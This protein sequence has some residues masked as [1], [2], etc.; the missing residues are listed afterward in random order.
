MQYFIIETT[1]FPVSHSCPLPLYQPLTYYIPP[2]SEVHDKKQKT[3]SLEDDKK[4]DLGS[5]ARGFLSG[6]KSTMS[7]IQHNN[8]SPPHAQST[9]AATHSTLP[10]VPM[11]GVDTPGDSMPLDSSVSSSPMAQ[12]AGRL[13]PTQPE[14]EGE[15]TTKTDEVMAG[16][17]HFIHEGGEDVLQ[18]KQTLAL[19]TKTARHVNAKYRELQRHKRSGDALAL[20]STA[21]EECLAEITAFFAKLPTIRFKKDPTATEEGVP[22]ASEINLELFPHTTCLQLTGLHVIHVKAG[23]SIQKLVLNESSSLQENLAVF[24]KVTEVDIEGCDLERILPS[25][26]G[27]VTAL[28]VAGVVGWS[29]QTTLQNHEN[30]LMI[31]VLDAVNVGWEEIPPAVSALVELTHLNV[32]GNR[33]TQLQHLGACKKLLSLNISLNRISSLKCLMGVGEESDVSVALLEDLDASNNP[34]T[35]V[36]GIGPWLTSIRSLNL[37]DCKLADWNQLNHL[38]RIPTLKAFSLSGNPIYTQ[39]GLP[40]TARCLV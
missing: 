15:T 13:S 1:P 3:M 37:A 27:D 6:L 31:T 39:P 8:N 28:R 34:I 22:E 9:H 33:I 7:K 29:L 2:P 10:T 17:Q 19:L 18:Q 38:V 32:S 36:K 35:E 12:S 30:L 21:D 26:A 25:V 20:T 14:E 5:K 24:P 11:P 23:E 16:I 4:G 40:A